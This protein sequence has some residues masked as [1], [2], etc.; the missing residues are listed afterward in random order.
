L[1]KGQSQ[2]PERL[3]ERSSCE[4]ETFGKIRQALEGEPIM[5]WML[6]KYNGFMNIVI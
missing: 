6:W 5:L 2:P 4:K 1:G 3:V